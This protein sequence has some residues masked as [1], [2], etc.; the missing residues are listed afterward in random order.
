MSSGVFRIG[1]AVWALVSLGAA[2][3]LATLNT[4]NIAVRIKV[5]RSR[6][7]GAVTGFAALA[8]TVPL[9][10]PL[11][12]DW[13]APW[14]VPIIAVFGILCVI[15]IDF[16]G[17]RGISGLVM[18]AA[19]YFLHCSFAFD[20][21]CALFGCCLSWLAAAGAI[22]AA[23]KPC[24]M[25]DGA[26]FLAGRRRRRLAAAALAAVTALYCACEVAIL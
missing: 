21:P 6:V 26:I 3:W 22:A 13:L 4:G 24:W 10:G 8:L 5:F 7:V 11:L 14:Y 23:A 9:A 16:V 12:W 1:L 20:I 2:L 15:F 17:S 19:Y 25:R 18:M